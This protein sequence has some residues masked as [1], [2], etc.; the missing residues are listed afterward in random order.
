MV[1]LHIQKV[2]IQLCDILNN[3]PLADDQE[4]LLETDEHSQSRIG[5]HESFADDKSAIRTC[6]APDEKTNSGNTDCM[7]IVTSP[8]H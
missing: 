4:R 3:Y 8:A 5:F 1:Y 7:V 6:P 2:A